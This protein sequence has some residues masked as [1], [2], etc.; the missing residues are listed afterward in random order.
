MRSLAFQ[1]FILLFAVAA[2]LATPAD[3]RE[4]QSLYRFGG[5]VDGN[6]SVDRLW[7][8]SAGNLYGVTTVNDEVL[9][10]VFVLSAGGS[11]TVLH[12]FQYQAQQASVPVGGVVMDA[13][14]NLY[15][16][17]ANG[18]AYNCPEI[19]GLNPDCGSIYRLATDGTLTTI[20]SFQGGEDG[21]G[22]SGGLL[23]DDAGNLFGTT[24]YD[25]APGACLGGGGCGTVFKLAANGTKTVL[26]NFTGGSDGAK[27]TGALI[28]DSQ[29]NLYGTT[30]LGGQDHGTVFKLA[31]NGTE[32]QLYAFNGA[33]GNQPASGLAMDGAGNL[34]G[35]T[36][37]GGASGVYGEVFKLAPNGSL[38]ALHSFD[39]AAGDGVYP[40]GGLAIDSKG[41]LYGTTTSGGKGCRSYGCGTVFKISRKGTYTQ[42]A[43]LNGKTAHNPL[44]GLI[45]D[46]AGVLYGSALGPS[47]DPNY[48]GVLF[49]VRKK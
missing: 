49:E 14:G 46:S 43:T 22:P 26:Y 3:A 18:G 28:A 25:G 34:Y 12:A 1:R 20:Y 48:L 38:T 17:A 6:A 15:G 4:F 41:N 9:G 32:T 8:D 10:T 16:E 27:P 2:S 5:G 44:G 33:D 47:N 19:D 29:G 42:L 35:T 23:I 11:E 45:V 40:T 13:Q 24:K 39:N 37:T 36:P 21:G 30:T 7:R 31:P